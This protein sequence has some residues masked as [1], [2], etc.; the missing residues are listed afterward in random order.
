MVYS[1]ILVETI[2][3]FLCLFVLTKVLGKSQITQ[4]T[5]F[6]FI[7]AL[8]LGELVGNALYDQEVGVFQV[9]FA[10]LCWGILIYVTEWITEKYKGSR[11]LLE[12]RPTIIIYEGKIQ[13]ELL[14]KGKLDI[15]QLQHLLRAKDVFSI[16]EVEYAILET[17]GTVS[18]LKKSLDQSPNRRDLNLKPERVYLPRT[19]VSDGEILWDNLKEADLTEEWL[20]H[21]L[22]QQNIHSPKELMYAEY[23]EGEALYVVPY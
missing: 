6:D 19:L 21:Q 4:I 11:A 16:Q 1:S 3:G 7:A 9:L 18:V 12:G 15:N 13:K 22:K 17:D 23:K 2:V 20:N 8:V 10:V 14:K 5:A